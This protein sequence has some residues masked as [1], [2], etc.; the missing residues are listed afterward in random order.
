M[1]GNG[2]FG[3]VVVGA[4]VAQVFTIG[5]TDD[6]TLTLGTVSLESNATGDFVINSAPPPGTEVIQGTPI[7]VT[8]TCAPTSTGPRT[9]ELHVPS[10]SSDGNTNEVIALECNGQQPEISVAPTELNF[11]QRNVGTSASLQ[12]TISNGTGPTVSPLTI[13]SIELSGANPFAVTVPSSPITLDPGGSIQAT[14]S[15]EPVVSGAF[16]A[17]LLINSDDPDNL[18]EPVALAGVGMDLAEIAISPGALSFG[19]VTVGGLSQLQFTIANAPGVFRRDL[20]VSSVV[21]NTGADDF[22]VDTAGPATIPPGASVTVTTTFMPTESGLRTGSVR[23][24]SD[25]A[26]SPD[27]LS[28]AGTGTQPDIAVSPLGLDFGS[29]GVTQSSPAQIVTAT[30]NGN[31]DL[32]ISKVELTNDTDFSFSGPASV[33]VAPGGSASWSVVCTPATTGAHNGQF[34]ISSD[35]PDTPVEAVALSCIGIDSL[36]GVAPQA[37]FPDTYINTE[38]D[39]LTIALRNN[40]TANDITILSVAVDLGVFTLSGLPG[41]PFTIP[42]SGEQTFTVDFLPLANQSYA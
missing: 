10:D 24:I 35:D 27:T 15:F 6:S 4:P 1:Q 41:G 19:S 21:V 31:Q 5:N 14:V 23:V 33:T 32:T 8:V 16:T 9:A 12:V 18:T 17:T 11:G 26:G 42:G 37:S 7:S 28:L 36:L 22:S 29:V 30:N 34:R 20:L 13:S 38:A 2:D 40:Q 25:D 39:S 3:D